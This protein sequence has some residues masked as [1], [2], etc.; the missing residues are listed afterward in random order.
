[1]ILSLLDLLQGIFSLLFVII[2]IIIVI[3]IL[4]KFIQNQKRTQ[5]LVGFGL[6]GLSNPWLP[7]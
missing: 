6:I 3:N 5:F 1:M 7:E 4:I 2:T